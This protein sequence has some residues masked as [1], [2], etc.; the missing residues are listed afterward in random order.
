M[1]KIGPADVGIRYPRFVA[2]ERRC[3]P[4]DVGGLPGFE[5]FL[6]AMG[7]LVHEEHSRLLE[8]Y[9][10]PYAPGRHSTKTAAEHAVAAIANRRHAGKAAYEKSRAMH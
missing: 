4:E 8:W 7:D 6:E 5:L 9:G 10:G 2:G 1:E 3:P